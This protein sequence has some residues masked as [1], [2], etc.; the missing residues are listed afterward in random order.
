MNITVIPIVMGAHGKNFQKIYKD[1]GKLGNK[2]T[3][4]ADPKNSI[5]RIVRILRRALET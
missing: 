5:L 1:T 2:K 3:N 4:E